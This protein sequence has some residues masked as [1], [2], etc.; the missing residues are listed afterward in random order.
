MNVVSRS[1]EPTVSRLSN[2]NALSGQRPST[3]IKSAIMSSA[4]GVLSGALLHG[5]SRHTGLSNALPTAATQLPFF[6]LLEIEQQGSRNLANQK[7]P[8]MFDFVGS[9][10][11]RSS[12][13][14]VA[15][16]VIPSFQ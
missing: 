3:N 12:C 2:K 15:A 10:Y 1:S 5:D 16:R 11:R 8:K 4:L 6:V 14:R 9:S 7:R 13:F